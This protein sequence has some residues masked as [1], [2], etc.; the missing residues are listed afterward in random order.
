[1]NENLIEHKFQVNRSEKELLNAHKG[2]VFWLTGLSGSGKSTI[3]DLAERKLNQNKNR[4]VLLDGDSVRKGLCKDLGFSYEDRRENLRRVAEASKLFA[5]NGNIV[6]CCFIS[7]L[8]EQRRMVS[9]ILKEDLKLIYVKASLKECENRDPKGLY[10]K[11]RTGEIQDFTGVS[12]KYEEPTAPSLI[13]N[14]EETSKE[15]C[16]KKLTDF[17]L[18]SCRLLK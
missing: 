2:R 6:I 3:A 1:V 13:L 9:E 12:S 17:I 10:K 16:A 15:D 14:S 11:A 7:P 4:I 8:E 5:I 18:D